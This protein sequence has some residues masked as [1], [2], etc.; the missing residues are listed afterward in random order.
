MLASLT[1]YYLKEKMNYCEGYSISSTF[2]KG[3]FKY[4]IYVYIILCPGKGMC[5]SSIS[6]FV[7]SLFLCAWVEVAPY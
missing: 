3:I 5:F 6:L 1:R 2:W 4:F 7:S